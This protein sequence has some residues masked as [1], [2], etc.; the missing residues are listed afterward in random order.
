MLQFEKGF[1]NIFTVSNLL[2]FFR[3]ILIVP[4]IL[5]FLKENYVAACICVVLSGIS[6]AL[7][8]F[9]ARRFNQVTELGKI[10][11][12]IADK[13]TLVAVIICVGMIINDIIPLVIILVTK[14]LLMLCGG[15]F[16]LK[17][18]ITPPAAKWF[19]KVSTAI[20][21]VSIVIIVFGK[22]FFNYENVVLTITLLIVTACAMI[23]ALV[24]YFIMFIRLLKDKKKNEIKEEN[25]HKQQQKL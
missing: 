7:D 23:F 4:F 19:G 20:F 10:L 2:T 11:D 5:F 25:T 17:Q 8:G 13:L 24:N 22:A 14:D 18:G 9:I 16:L 3:I 1:K 21:Y 15:Y 12:P 6:D